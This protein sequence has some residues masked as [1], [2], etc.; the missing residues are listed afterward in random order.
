MFLPMVTKMFCFKFF[1]QILLGSCL[2]CEPGFELGKIKISPVSS[3]YMEKDIT[4]TH[5]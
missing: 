4:T 3:S 1:P 5:A 2:S